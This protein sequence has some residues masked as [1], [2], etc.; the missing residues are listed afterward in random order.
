MSYWESR[1]LPLTVPG[2]RSSQKPKMDISSLL[3][4][5]DSPRDT[6]PPPK[7]T[8]KKPRRPRAK[9]NVQAKSSPTSHSS[10]PSSTLTHMIPSPPILHPPSALRVNATHTPPVDGSRSARQGSTP[11]MDTLADLASMQHHQQATRANAGGLRSTEIYDSQNPANS[12]APNFFGVPGSLPSRASMDLAMADAATETP[13]P[14]TYSA[15]S[16]SEEELQMVTNL[17]GDLATNP[18]AY[19]SHVQL[20][21]VLHRGLRSHI[22]P[23]SPSAPKGDPR[24]YDLLSDLQSAREA[25]DAR[26]ALGEELWIDYIEDQ[27]LFATTFEECIA[28]MELCLKAVQ[29]ESASTKL[30]SLY[31][32]WMLSMYWAATN[33]PKVQD[34]VG[35]P[36]Q[37]QSWTEEDKMVAREVCNWQQ[38]MDVWGRGSQATMWRIDESHII[39]NPYT[40]LLLQNLAENPTGE[41]ILSMKTHFFERLQVPHGNWDDT[42][43]M[44][45][46]F[47]SRFDNH[48]YEDI[49]M[50]VNRECASTKSAYAAREMLEIGLRR[51]GE[52]GNSNTHL[53]V[54]NEYIEWEMAQSR[55]K[56]AFVFE[57]VDGLYQR[58][59]FN[60]P[61]NTGL[62]ESYMMFL[63][64]EIISQSREDI[65]LLQMYD[66]AT[67]HCPW[68]GTLWSQYLL[69]AER[70]KMPFT[71][72]D[73]IKHKA[74]ST[75]LLDAGGL[76]E[77]L[78]VYV[79][80]CSVL[81]RRAFQEESTD[82]E[83]DVAEVGIRS[84]IEDMQRL[85]EGKYGQEY[86]GDPNYRLERIYIKYLT[87]SRNWHAARE[88]WKTLIA[89]RGDNH[90]FWIRYYLW[91]MGAWA[92]ISYSENTN[93]VPNSPR[94]SEATRV[95]R[96]GLKRPK[97][98]WPEKILEIFQSHCEDHEDAEELQSASV[99]IWKIKKVINKRRERE[100]IEAYQAAQEQTI[101][102]AQTLK[103]EASADS[104]VSFTS[105][106]RKREDG[107]EDIQ[108]E[109]A[110]K[111]TRGSKHDGGSEIERLPATAG[112]SQ[113][114]RDREN[115]SIVIKNLPLGTTET[116]IKQFFRDVGPINH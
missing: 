72:I 14:R 12:T 97:L 62:W 53:S 61:A 40:E 36:N 66:R 99:L 15:G 63:N 102:Q 111:K 65:P 1:L 5:Q 4:P 87:Q 60:F 98:D 58:A 91:E 47:I 30:W 80:W 29:E 56:R 18:F 17:V 84:A 22:R 116:R 21:N 96:M 89:L 108:D 37:I 24:T 43:Q 25:M 81:R 38:V 71:D 11:G 106:K 26:F 19:E 64:D 76:E 74:T 67:K 69:A 75:G 107:C 45:S 23:S 105:S 13:P 51:S 16:L 2:L 100:A 114:K 31:A 113:L 54:F 34:I 35:E 86:Q 109:G 8:P 48:A 32:N 90:E 6:P 104:G 49:M 28:V 41:G 77:I 46:N 79:A 73:N 52:S 33:D 95:L 9:S 112:P 82:E 7:A 83:L 103:P 115:A 68:S 93:N 57:L 70:Q 85:G 42:F 20:I 39:W 110:L 55:K 50:S 10:I 3:S 88:Y 101:Q 44:F 78:Q 59:T 92:K 27:K 94:P